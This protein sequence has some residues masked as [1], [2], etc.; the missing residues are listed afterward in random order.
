MPCPNCWLLS[1]TSLQENTSVFHLPLNC[2]GV[3]VYPLSFMMSS[4]P[5]HI[6][7]WH[8]FFIMFSWTRSISCL[9]AALVHTVHACKINVTVFTCIANTLLKCFIFKIISI[10]LLTKTL[11]CS[12][13][14]IRYF[15]D[16]F[17]IQNCA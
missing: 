1:L 8:E 10:R 13:I 17:I 12:H 2:L 6:L 4:T 11:Q 15:T 7:L 9:V 3:N 14:F 16:E 5:F